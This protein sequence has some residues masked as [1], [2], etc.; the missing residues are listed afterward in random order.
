LI[1]ET[2]ITDS[3]AATSYQPD[4]ACDS[5]DNIHIVWS[6]VRDSGP[7]PNIELYYE[8]LDNFGNTLVDETR[9]TFAPHNSH[10][11]SMTMDTSDNVNVAWVE[12]IDIMGVLQ[13]EIYYMKLDNNGNTLV[14][15]TALTENDAEESLFPDIE[16]DS[17][18]EVH[19]VWLDDRKETPW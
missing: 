11:P 14:D 16:V 7:I 1:D 2:L 8:K 6:D 18:G 17:D 10:Y 5:N 3:D 15:T 9:I 19:I 4:I 12:Q 13:E